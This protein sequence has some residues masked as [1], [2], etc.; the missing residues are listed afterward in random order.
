MGTTTTNAVSESIV[1]M[2]DRQYAS[3]AA[4]SKNTRLI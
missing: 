4:A 2:K 1:N 3:L